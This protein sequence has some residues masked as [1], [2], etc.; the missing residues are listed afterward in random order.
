[1]S[2]VLPQLVH[3]RAMS[4]EGDRRLLCEVGGD[5]RSYREI[6]RNARCWA[7]RLDALGVKRGDRVAV[8]L[9]TAIDA[10]LVWLACGWLAAN[11]VPIHAQFQGAILGHVVNNSGAEI[12]IVGSEYLDGFFGGTNGLKTLRQV[13]VVSRE[14]ADD[15]MSR[16]PSAWRDRVIDAATLGDDVRP[17]DDGP[18]YW[19]TGSIIY[20]SGTTGAPKG[21]IVPWRLFLKHGQITLPLSDVGADDIFYCPLPLSHIAGRVGIYNMVL[22]GGAAVLRSRFS[23]EEYWA[24]IAAYGCTG[25]IMMGSM[26]EMLWQRPAR[27]DDAA[28]PL[29]NILMGPLIP[30]V[31]AFKARFDVRVRTQFGMTEVAAPLLS[32]IRDDWDLANLESCGRVAPGFE[33]RLA[34]EYDEAVPLGEPGE[35]LVRSTDPWVIT[36]GYWKDPANTA[37]AFRNQWFHTGDVFRQDDEGN[38]YFLDRVKDTIRRRGENISSFFVE[39]IIL[40]HPAITECAVVGVASEYT[41][42]DIHAFIVAGSGPMPTD[43]E[44]L[45]FVTGKLPKFMIPQVWTAIDALPRTPTGRVRKVELRERVLAARAA[46]E[47][48]QH[49]A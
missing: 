48:A 43:K 32:G 10:F 40:D 41:E 27:A 11:E 21:V 35:L 34:D 39:Q 26:A 16:I 25:T 2:E 47:T 45:A 17:A 4:A 28:T 18:A 37:Q 24:D 6:D 5:W 20:T 36:P 44:L 46:L 33:V 31:E 38:F 12:A 42:Q 9:P 1:M 15:W 3:A 29:R 49:A 23:I 14:Q 13:V 7:A 22:V 19:D 8:M 30:Q